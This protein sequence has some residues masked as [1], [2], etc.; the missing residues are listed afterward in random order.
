MIDFTRAFRLADA[1]KAP[2]TLQHIDRTPLARLRTLDAAAVR[3]VTEHCVSTF[4]AAA[5]MK[6]RDALVAHF[7][8]LWRPRALAP[9]STERSRRRPDGSRRSKIQG[10]RRPQAT[11]ITAV[12]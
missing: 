4:E 5:L 2:E 9:C 6:R 10:K 3:E 7:D 1:L 12:M 11:V 8:T